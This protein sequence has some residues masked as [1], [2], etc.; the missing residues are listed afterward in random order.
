MNLEQF[1]HLISNV[2][3]FCANK[4][5]DS[6]LGSDLNREFGDSSDLFSQIEQACHQGV[7]DGWMCENGDDQRRWGRII[8]PGDATHG[9]SVDVVYLRDLVGPHHRHPTGEIDMIMPIADSAKFDSNPRGWLVYEADSAHRPTVSEGDAYILYLLP[10]GEIE[11][12]GQ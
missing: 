2:T 5:V 9:F 11:F 7:K 10:N 3:A 1:T 6:A 12:T 8:K 4:P